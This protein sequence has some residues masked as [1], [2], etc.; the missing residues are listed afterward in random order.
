MWSCKQCTKWNKPVHTVCAAC[1]VKREVPAPQEK[2]TFFRYPLPSKSRNEAKQKSF[3]YTG[4]Y[5]SVSCMKLVGN[6]LYTGCWDNTLSSW[7]TEDQSQ[8]RAF[9]GHEDAIYAIGVN[10]GDPAEGIWAFDTLYSG[11]ADGTVRSWNTQSGARGGG[12]IHEFKGHTHFVLCLCLGG[13]TPGS[14]LFTGSQDTTCRVWDTA[15]GECLHLFSGHSRAVT[16]IK[17]TAGHLY[18]TSMD[19]ARS[20]E[21]RASTRLFGQSEDDPFFPKLYKEE[22][23]SV[24]KETDG[25]Q[26]NSVRCWDWRSGTVLYILRGHTD[27]ILCLDV[28]TAPPPPIEPDAH[29]HT[30]NGKKALS[31]FNNSVVYTGSADRTAKAWDMGSGTCS[32]TFTGHMNSVSCIQASPAGAHLYTGSWDMAAAKWDA[33]TGELLYRFEG[34]TDRLRCIAF[35]DEVLSHS[36]GSLSNGSL[37]A[38]QRLSDGSLSRCRCSTPARTTRRCACGT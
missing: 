37:T 21:D 34:H 17:V 30:D 25:G 20:E 8:I 4:H 10:P 32:A 11:S 18:T 29:G 24:F 2:Q 13:A 12:T 14:R 28:Y 23:V 1:I 5:K 38:L 27:T 33:A 19:Y 16:H 31:P 26:D 15:T 3:T 36:N 9:K 6:V 7:S 35:V 22:G